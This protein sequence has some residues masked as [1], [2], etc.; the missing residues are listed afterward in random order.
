MMAIGLTA[1]IAVA[2]PVRAE[3]EVIQHRT[4]ESTHVRTD[5]APA[6]EKERVI[7]R[8]AAPAAV[9]RR[10]KETT[11]TKGHKSDNDND[12]DND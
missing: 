5:T 7:E 10:S 1:L 4:Q 12:D 11:V 9:E 8:Q 6:V 2:S 3:D